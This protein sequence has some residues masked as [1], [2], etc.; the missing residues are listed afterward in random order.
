[1]HGDIVKPRTL[2][3]TAHISSALISSVPVDKKVDFNDG[4]DVISPETFLVK[5]LQVIM[6][7]RKKG[8]SS[9]GGSTRRAPIVWL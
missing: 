8:G 7:S 3:L 5:R 1:M 2:V 9:P 4:Q 6:D